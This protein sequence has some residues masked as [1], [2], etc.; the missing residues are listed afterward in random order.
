[1]SVQRNTELI[2]QILANLDK[3][4]A[5]T[6]EQLIYELG[7]MIGMLSRMANNNGEI[8]AELKRILAQQLKNSKK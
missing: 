8:H 3:D 2:K 7:Y 5:N 6:H 1:M 4:H